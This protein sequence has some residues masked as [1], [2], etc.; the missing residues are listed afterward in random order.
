MK[1]PECIKVDKKS[2][3]TEGVSSSTLMYFPRYYD[4]DGKLHSHDNNTHTTSYS[5]SNGHSWSESESGSC[6]CGWGKKED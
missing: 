5:C 6:W 4:E 1:C 3:V 2:C